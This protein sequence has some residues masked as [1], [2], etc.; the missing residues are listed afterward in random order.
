LWRASGTTEVTSFELFVDLLYVGILAING[1]HAA[2]DPTGYELLRFTITFIMSWKIWSDVTTLISW[3][4]TDDILQRLS[5]LFIMACLLGL[6][7]NMLDA[8]ESTYAQLIAF[9]IAARLFMTAYCVALAAVVPMV[10]PM[11]ITQ[12]FIALIPS[13]LWIG[14]IYVELPHRFV[15]IWIAIFLDLSG[16]MF[17]VSL[18]RSSKFISKSFGERM[19]KL[20]E[21]Y[22]A[23]N[24]EHKVERTNA[25]VTLVFGTYLQLTGSC[26]SRPKPCTN[27][28]K[29]TPLWPSSTRM[30]LRLA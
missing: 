7:T 11:M 16:S 15:I 5:I 8:F 24:I 30:P 21:F 23:V 10:R 26:I 22:P 1:D 6:T 19:E 28:A 13:I 4:E 20:Y 18:I 29:A 17:L 3:F 27:I 25:F 9:Y 12:A 2:E 14:S